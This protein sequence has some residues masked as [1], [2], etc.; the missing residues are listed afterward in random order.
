MV[1]LKQLNTAADFWLEI[2]VPDC[3]DYFAAETNLRRALHAS[4]SLFHMSDWVF[5]THEAQ[6]RSAF[7]YTDSKS[8]V[9]PVS[10]ASEFA[11]ALEQ[12]NA[13]FGRIRGIANAAKHLELTDIRPVPNAPSHAANTAIQ[14]EFVGAGGYGCAGGYNQGGVAYGASPKVML[15]GP[16]G[17]D[18]EFSNILRSVYGMWGTLKCTYGW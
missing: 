9:R 3:S 2:V 12:Q 5:H 17:S 6:V 4:I 1:V 11:T 10:K 13:D 7:T 18:M 16:N 15:A 14:T 8:T